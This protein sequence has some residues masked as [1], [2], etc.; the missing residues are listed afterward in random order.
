MKQLTFLLAL[1]GSLAGAELGNK[2]PD[3]Q[4]E[5]SVNLMTSEGASLVHA[6]WRYS[7][8]KIVEVNFTGP[9]ADGQPSGKPVKTYDYSPHAGGVEFDDSGW[10]R[11]GPESLDQRR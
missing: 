3:A 1:A 8:T 11:I 5:A 7:D 10:E 9:G 2:I 6:Q 4:P